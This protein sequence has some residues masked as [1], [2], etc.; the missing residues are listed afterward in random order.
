[1]CNLQAPAERPLEYRSFPY[2]GMEPD[3]AG[4][5]EAICTGRNVLDLQ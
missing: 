2:Q 5:P 1:M 4:A 3:E